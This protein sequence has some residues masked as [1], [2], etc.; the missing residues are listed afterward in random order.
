VGQKATQAVSRLPQRTHT[1]ADPVRSWSFRAPIRSGGVVG[2]VGRL[3]ASSNPWVTGRSA[4]GQPSRS[5]LTLLVMLLLDVLE[6]CCYGGPPFILA[7]RWGVHFAPAHARTGTN[8]PWRSY[9]S[10]WAVAPSLGHRQHDGPH[11]T[12]DLPAAVHPNVTSMH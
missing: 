10:R 4:H 6:G 11:G 9:R 1:T 12:S 7:I 3:Q 5:R 8:A 2:V